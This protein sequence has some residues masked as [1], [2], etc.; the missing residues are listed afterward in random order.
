MLSP[1]KWL[2]QQTFKG[3]KGS[4][5]LQP[6][7]PCALTFSPPFIPVTAARPTVYNSLFESMHSTLPRPSLPQILIPQLS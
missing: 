7:K 2:A 4:D 6:E 5:Q 1:C 3:R